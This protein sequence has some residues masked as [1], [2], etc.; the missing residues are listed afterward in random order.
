MI[1]VH[2]RNSGIA[3]LGLGLNRIRDLKRN[4]VHLRMRAEGFLLQDASVLQNC[5]VGLVD[6][7]LA[8]CLMLLVQ[9]CLGHLVEFRIRLLHGSL[10]VLGR[11]EMQCNFYVHLLFTIF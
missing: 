10:Y 6:R 8:R 9:Q 3:I 7:S 11:P 1:V 5:V 4:D 2:S